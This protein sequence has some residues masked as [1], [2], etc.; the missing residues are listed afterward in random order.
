MPTDDGDI[1]K[2]VQEIVE[3]LD[4]LTSSLEATSRNTKTLLKAIDANTKLTNELLD[5][6]KRGARPKT[7]SSF[8]PVS[9]ASY[10]ATWIVEGPVV[11]SDEDTR[12]VLGE[13]D[14]E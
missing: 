12:I 13:E 6:A 11:L 3:R 4:R 10:Q 5:I 2:S 7:V 1:A 9:G 14:E 8:E